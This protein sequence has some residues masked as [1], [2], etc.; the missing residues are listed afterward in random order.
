M[1]RFTGFFLATLAM[2]LLIPSIAKADS[3]GWSYTGTN[4]LN[5]KIITAFGTLTATPVAGHSG[6]YLISAGTIN[7]YQAGVLI[8]SGNLSNINLVDLFEPGITDGT[9]IDYLN[10]D[11]HFTLTSS[12]LATLIDF[13][14]YS[15]DD[16]KNGIYSD[17]GFTVYT[18]EPKSLILLGTG[19]LGLAGVVFFRARRRSVVSVNKAEAA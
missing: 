13:Y 10:N 4:E 7:L 6:E 14:G 18:P 16:S 3:F 17:G 15:L 5:G 2:I 1:R 8:G 9:V 12:A 11:L 19:L